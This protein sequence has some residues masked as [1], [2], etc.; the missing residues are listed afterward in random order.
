MATDNRIEVARESGLTLYAVVFRPGDLYVWDVGDSAFEAPGTWNAARVGACDIP[1]TEVAGT[2]MYYGSF[3]TT[4]V[5]G[6]Y[7]VRI[8][9]QTGANP[10]PDADID[11]GGGTVSWTGSRMIRGYDQAARNHAYL[12]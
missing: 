7:H 6:D 5:G 3:P 1:L 4:I 12:T 10:D 8:Y 9:Q 2:G 11:R